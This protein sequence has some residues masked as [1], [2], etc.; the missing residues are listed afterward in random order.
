MRLRV[1]RVRNDAKLPVRAHP[2]DAGMDLFY[3]PQETD[4]RLYGSDFCVHPNESK[5]VPTGIK[6]EVPYGYML[7]VKNKSSVAAKKQLLV[8]AC[9]VDSGYNGEVFVNLHNV[10]TQARIIQPG[11]KIAQAVLI[12]VQPCEV[13]DHPTDDLNQNSTR[14]EGA[15]GST[16]E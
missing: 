14:G 2:S 7:E 13:V 1:F 8:G 9:V 12:P 4:H 6:V 3:C 15:L 5:I 16:G 11:Q 10:G